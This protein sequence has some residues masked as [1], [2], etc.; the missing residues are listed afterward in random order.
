MACASPIIGWSKRHFSTE[1]LANKSL[2]FKKSYFIFVFP[3]EILVYKFYTVSV[4]LKTTN[5]MFLY[6]KFILY[7]VYFYSIYSLNIKRNSKIFPKKDSI[8]HL[9]LPHNWDTQPLKTKVANASSILSASRRFWISWPS[10]TWRPV[11]SMN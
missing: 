3:K 9:F 6:K 8:F 4:R 11:K 2:N 1:I 7:K 10:I 5:L